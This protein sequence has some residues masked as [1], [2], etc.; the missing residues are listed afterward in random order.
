MYP[1]YPV[2]ASAAVVTAV[3]NPRFDEDP[4]S[5]ILM[6]RRPISGIPNRPERDITS[7][8]CTC[9]HSVAPTLRVRTQDRRGPFLRLFVRDHGTQHH[10]PLAPRV[11]RVS[12][13]SP[14]A[15]PVASWLFFWGSIS[16]SEG[17]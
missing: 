11:G 2:G 17:G 15:L 1:L 5:P 13:T 16:D 12:P 4:T 6:P 7:G 10:A 3:L 8:F 14:G 9:G